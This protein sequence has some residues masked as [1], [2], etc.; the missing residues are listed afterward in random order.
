MFKSGVRKL[1]ARLVVFTLGDGKRL[2]AEKITK[3]FDK[4]SRTL[5]GFRGN[6][7]FFDDR[8]GEYRA[9]NYWDTKS[10]AEDANEVMFP[11]L[12]NELSNIS[13]KKP[14]VKM[15]EVYDPADSQGVMF[16]HMKI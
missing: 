2:L 5:R 7:Y 10:D 11:K 6:V 13:E 16:S 15:F 14:V 8:V 9:L 1:Y 3:E 12:E 4:V